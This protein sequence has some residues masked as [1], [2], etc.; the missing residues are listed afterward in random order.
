MGLV[1]SNRD[2]PS[3]LTFT[4]TASGTMLGLQSRLF[5]LLAWALQFFISVFR[6]RRDCVRPLLGVFPAWTP[7]RTKNGSCSHLIISPLSRLIWAVQSISLPFPEW[8][9]HFT[10][11]SFPDSPPSS[12][13]RGLVTLQQAPSPSL[14]PPFLLSH[15]FTP[16]KI[17]F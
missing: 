5:Q 6:N 2:S 9:S 12:S 17:S 16:P 13:Q 8:G 14:T 15:F 3:L 4:L 7:H 10:T 1:A 11:S